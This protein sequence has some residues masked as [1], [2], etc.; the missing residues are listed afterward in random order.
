MVTHQG[1]APRRARLGG[2]ANTRLQRA[3]DAGRE[4]LARVQTEPGGQV[5]VRAAL[6]G[7][8]EDIHLA[9]RPALGLFVEM[10]DEFD[11]VS[12]GSVLADVLRDLV[13]VLRRG[14]GRD[15]ERAT[16]EDLS[17]LE[18]EGFRYILFVGDVE[19]ERPLRRVRRK[20]RRT[21]ERK[22]GRKGQCAPPARS[23]G[24]GT[25]QG[26]FIDEII[27]ILDDKESKEKGTGGVTNDKASR[28][29]LPSRRTGR[30]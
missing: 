26:R 4:G 14:D 21:T 6:G 3:V 15:A 24:Q 29:D 2:V 23:R 5:G 16:A 30:V 1:R 10:F 20:K 27:T 13:G 11:Q 8:A 9:L 12:G 18:R 25:Q 19:E 7:L 28:A 17:S 22:G